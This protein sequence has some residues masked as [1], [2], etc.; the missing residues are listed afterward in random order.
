MLPTFLAFFVLCDQCEVGELG[1]CWSIN[2]DKHGV[3]TLQG[4][5]RKARHNHTRKA[6]PASTGRRL[7]TCEPFSE[8]SRHCMLCSEHLPTPLPLHHQDD[9]LLSKGRDPR[10]VL[11]QIIRGLRCSAIL[12]WYCPAGHRHDL[13]S[14]YLNR[15]IAQ[16]RTVNRATDC[17]S[18]RQR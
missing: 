6:R 17:T 1:M 8:R 2:V 12:A 7:I 5:M 10:V 14:P 18:I 11:F 13:P 3:K 15:A 9:L 4:S 16:N